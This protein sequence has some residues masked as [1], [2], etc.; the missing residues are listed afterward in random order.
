MRRAFEIEI[1]HDNPIARDH[2]V[3]GAR[4]VPG[5]TFLELVRGALR[6][7][8]ASIEIRDL[9]FHAPV[10][11]R[12]GETRRVQVVVDGARVRITSRGLAGPEDELL[13]AECIVAT[14]NGALAPD[15]TIDPG[16]LRCGAIGTADLD[17]V[18]RFAR[19]VGIEHDG[20]MRNRGHVWRG[21]DHVLLE[22][23]LSERAR[24]EANGFVLHPALL[25]GATLTVVPAVLERLG[26]ARSGHAYVPLH[27]R[28]FRCSAALGDRCL[29]LAR[30]PADPRPG[31]DVYEIDLRLFDVTGR[32][33]ATL[34][35]LSVKRVR[36]AD[37]IT[38][39]PRES[40]ARIDN[41]T[42]ALVE[43]ER[44]PLKRVR[45]LVGAL[46]GRS[47]DAL[48]PD[49]PFYD[50]GL[51]SRELVAIARGL[52]RAAG[53]PLYPT[54]LFEHDTLRRLTTHLLGETPS[55]FAETSS[56]V[57]RSPRDAEASGEPLELLL[58]TP[59]WR[60]EPIIAPAPTPTTIA[61]VDDGDPIADA[62]ASLA[63]PHL[64]VTRE[65]IG[66]CASDAAHWERFAAQFD[67]APAL[68]HVAGTPDAAMA[69]ALVLRAF[70][71]RGLRPAVL[72]VHR[73]PGPVELEAL[74]AMLACAWREQRQRGRHLTIAPDV[75]IGRAAEIVLGEIPHAD[76]APLAVRHDGARR[77]RVRRIVRLEPTAPTAGALPRREAVIVITGGAGGLARIVAQH[78]AARCSARIAL[79]GRS[80]RDA[81]VEAACAGIE[82]AGGRALYVQADV[83]DR[84]AVQDAITTVREHFGGVHGV[85]HCA[86]VLRDA[87]LRDVGTDVMQSVLAPKL[88][89]ARHLDDATRGDDLEL[90]ALFS[91]ASAWL[92]NAAQSVYAWANAS[93]DAFAHARANEVAAGRRRGRTVSIAWPL[94]AEG[95]MRTDETAIAAMRDQL[96]LAP[97]PT[98][99][100]LDALDRALASD[101]T[102][103]APLAGNAITITRA[104]LTTQP[105]DVH[106]APTVARASDARVQRA[107]VRSD[108][109]GFDEPIAIIG[110]AGRYPG[111]REPRMLHRLVAE[112]RSE[113]RLAPEGRL[114]PEA[115]SPIHGAFLDDIARFDARLF[116]ITPHEAARMAPEER[117]FLETVWE[118]LED[119]AYTR[120]ALRAQADARDGAIGVFVGTTYSNYGRF[121]HEASDR[122]RLALASLYIVPNR[123]SHWFDLDGPSLAIDT[124][125]SGSLS[126]IHLACESLRRGECSAAIAGGVS[127]LLTPWRHVGF[128]EVGML[129]SGGECRTLGDGDGLVPGEGVGAVLLK[130]LA[131]ALRDGDHVH[132]VVLGSALS[133]GG[134]T[135]S[136]TAPNPRAQARA[137]RAALARAGVTPG[138]LGWIEVAAAGLPIA[139]AIEI[140]ALGKV[141]APRE[142]P[143]AIGSLKGAI[144]HLEAASG[145]AQLTKVVFQMADAVRV[146]TP[147][148]ER[149]RTDLD[150]ERARVRPQT[151]TEPWPR[152]Q[153]EPRR[154]VVS[155]FGAGGSNAHLVIEEAPPTH[156]DMA[157]GPELV[158]LSARDEAELA[159]YA[160]RLREHLTAHPSTSL[161]RV[162]YTLQVG[163]AP[164][165]TRAAIV[166]ESLDALVAALDVLARGDTGSASGWLRGVGRAPSSLAPIYGD[167]E[168]RGMLAELVARS[169][170]SK[171]AQLWS[172]GVAF[173]WPSLRRAAGVRRLALPVRPLAGE[174][175]WI[176]TPSREVE[177]EATVDVGPPH[178]AS[179]LAAPVETGAAGGSPTAHARW[180][181]IL[182]RHASEVLSVSAAA[183][184][185]D[186]DLFDLGIDSLALMRLLAR[187]RDAHAVRVRPDEVA[188]CRT[189]ASIAERLASLASGPRTTPADVAPV[190][191]GQARPH[192]PLSLNQE[193]IWVA[194]QIAPEATA[195]HVPAAFRVRGWLEPDAL[196]RAVRALAE[197]HPAMRTQVAMIDGTPQRR[198][199]PRP[200][201]GLE[202]HE[203]PGAS[204]ET[205]EARA[206]ELVHRPFDLE[207]GPLVRVHLITGADDARVVL[208]VAHHLVCDG[209]S[210]AVLIDELTALATGA[211]LAPSP[212]TDYDEFVE[213]QRAMLGSAD[214]D[215]HRAWFRR[216]LEA[217]LEAAT[218]PYD[219][220]RGAT[221]RFAGEYHTFGL[222]GATMSALRALCR[223]RGASLYHGLLAAFEAL[224]FR[225]GTRGPIAIATGVL[226]RPEPRFEGV[227]G[228]FSNVVPLRAEVDGELAFDALLQRVRE[229]ALRAIG[230]ADMPLLEIVRDRDRELGEA[231]PLTVCFALQNWFRQYGGAVRRDA[232]AIALD[233]IFT[234]H[235]AG[236]FDLTLMIYERDDDAIA[237]LKYDPDLFDRT[238]VER[239]AGHYATLLAA[240]V[241]TPEREISALPLLSRAELALVR[242]GWASNDR[243]FPDDVSLP[244]LVERVARVRA[245]EIAVRAPDGDVR[246]AEL[247]AR[248]SRL[249]VALCE[250]GV[251][252]GE[253][254]PVLAPR[255]AGL[256]TA[257][258]GAMRAG[259]AYVPIEPRLPAARIET[260][261]ADSRAR[262][263]M[264]ARAAVPAPRALLARLGERTAIETVV[265]LDDDT[266]VEID[267]TA[268][269][270]A[271]M[272]R[273][274]FSRGAPAPR[275][276]DLTLRFAARTLDRAHLAGAARELSERLRLE[277]VHPGAPVAI[278]FSD[279]AA[280]ILARLAID[281]LGARVVSLS[282]RSSRTESHRA[283][284]ASNA[285]ALVSE[286]AHVDALDELHQRS[287][288]ALLA[289]CVDDY[290]PGALPDDKEHAIRTVFD[291]FSNVDVDELSGYGWADSYE[292]R[293]FSDAEMRE[294]V[295]NFC[296][297]LDSL[298]T[299]SSRV[300][301]IGC[302]QGLVLFE[303]APRVAEYVAT[304]LTPAIIERNLQRVARRGLSGVTLLP[305]AARE[306]DRVPGRGTYDVVIASSV[307]H[308]FPNT[309]YLEDVIDRAIDLL[310]TQGAVYIDDLLDLD[311]K[312]SV[313]EEL[314][315]F[316]A[317]HPDAAPK[318]DWD[319]DLFVG[320]AFW[321]EIARRR[322]EIVSVE[323][324][325]KLGRIPNEL[326]RFRYDV[327]LRV[328]KS[329]AGAPR[330]AGRRPIVDLALFRA[331]PLDADRESPALGDAL[332]RL[333]A[334]RSD[335]HGASAVAACDARAPKPAVGPN[336]LAYVLYTSGSTGAPKGA[337]IEHVGM[338][339]HV[340]AKVHD[341]AIGERDVIVQNASQGFDISVWQMLTA[342]CVGGR[343]LV[344]DD[345]TVLEPRAF[346]DVITSE[347]ATILEVVPS[348]LAVLLEV[349]EA[350]PQV[351]LPALR[352]LLV[353]G[354]AV[355]PS[356]VERWL[357]RFP[358]I[359][360]VNAYGPTECSD[361]V[362][363]HILRAAPE[364]ETT[365]IGVPVS[366]FRIYVVDE[367]TQ[368]VPIGVPGE[369]VVSGVGVSRGY[370]ND[371]ERTA[372]AFGI[373]PF[374]G[375]DVRLYRTG[376]L[377]RWRSDGVLEFLGRRDHQVKIRG[378]RIE[379]GEIEARLAAVEGVADAVV[380]AREDERGDKQ[381][382]GYAVPR[383][384]VMLDSDTV[385][386]QLSETLPAAMVPA[387]VV[388]LA[389]LPV[390]GNGKVDRRALPKPQLDGAA[391]N[392]ARVVEAPRGDLEQAVADAFATVLAM[393]VDHVGRD[394]DFFV[395]GGDS[396]KAIQLSTHLRARGLAVRIQDF[397]ERPRV[398][399]HASYLRRADA[400]RRE[401]V[402]GD[403][404]LSPIQRWFLATYR[405]HRD[406][407]HHRAVLRVHDVDAGALAAA[408]RATAEH[409]DLFCARLAEQSDGPAIFVPEIPSPAALEIV[410]LGDAV[411]PWQ[412][413]ESHGDAWLERFD[414]A[415]G[416]LAA[417]HL[418]RS[419]GAGDVLVITAHHI[420]V[421]ATSWRVIFEDLA[422][423][424]RDLARGDRPNLLRS[425]PFA[426]VVHAITTSA[427]GEKG[428]RDLAWFRALT[429]G[430]WARLPGRKPVA[431][432]PRG[433][434]RRVSSTVDRAR[435]AELTAGAARYCRADL[436]DVLLTVVT[437]A[438]AEWA[439]SPRVLLSMESH[440]RDLGEHVD[441]GRTVGWLASLY[442]MGVEVAADR[443]LG[444]RLKSVKE[445]LRR[446]PGGGVAYG[447]ARWIEGD[448]SLAIDPEITFDF[449]GEITAPSNAPFALDVE[450]SGLR[451]APS[452][453]QEVP[454]A[455][456]A[457][458]RDGALDIHFGFHPDELDEAALSRLLRRVD[459][460]LEELVTLLRERDHAEATPSDYGARDVE[461]D[462]L[463]EIQSALHGIEL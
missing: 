10:V 200:L 432:R 87:L 45:A 59:T 111:A 276:G 289:I 419:A 193:A 35:G 120:E 279:P 368:L 152:E 160:L 406:W 329:R 141:L 435:I 196:D 61:L 28:R 26:P 393:P 222:D 94:W 296:T 340:F 54:L 359:P 155:A 342:L 118:L 56:D 181:D 86:A 231:P 257:M 457:V 148:A 389:S 63:S 441:A 402:T 81:R 70:S 226:G 211:E 173:D 462:E 232:P 360:V 77:R 139:D 323:A 8:E 216:A 331:A 104:V 136:V 295:E 434:C 176:G 398:D 316:K 129:A 319:Q 135:P 2:R 370:L 374:R 134:R 25:D 17:R 195:Y 237:V 412:A 166:I 260:I 223:A 203:L 214:A 115:G 225:Y 162:A 202:R 235:Q 273:A 161:A 183:L 47:P 302:G 137:L 130:P 170:W 133:H 13:H 459:A 330:A 217:P 351:A 131:N 385:R 123:V 60:D 248:A 305:L 40:A 138:S 212:A 199:A 427:A 108:R 126:A 317:E 332:G 75:A 219:R 11:A 174:R 33:V 453:P 167:D 64:R 430:E 325:P 153:G 362:T 187:V 69:L 282:P 23:A 46:T 443:D 144:G 266:N 369:I 262:V 42:P 383:P 420:A 449:F 306:I 365:P 258:L 186:D 109:E 213:W 445:A 229:H 221:R 180:I 439:A 314:R 364:G 440:G 121:A 366:N 377:G 386:T 215:A 308:Y 78:F 110:I 387:H 392:E 169:R 30:M 413:I 381:L 251:E 234:I 12:E 245:A 49:Q 354:E 179:A 36:S 50:L 113:I 88:A 31:A 107:G 201:A 5:V 395:L 204:L 51:E 261:L 207:A 418:Y 349:L 177:T 416:P 208:V 382:V 218:L 388:L 456:E 415:S 27:V 3:H 357:R 197:R 293:R 52:E 275:G 450:R 447:A 230:H 233:P 425:D 236:E 390:T 93:M 149:V 18:Y 438:I 220:P 353:T 191:T 39:G 159:A 14:D 291:A 437:S 73:A 37:R 55:L 90:F 442:P 185:A 363:H 346:L 117:L 264:A 198:I 124:A 67:T 228:D 243:P 29:V 247:D 334:A 4:V 84:A 194:Q 448:V 15:P 313:E 74:H 125:C 82:A 44:D 426:D 431:A 318:L 6:G 463:T 379:L 53:Q 400:S 157:V 252:L 352:W 451:T 163:R 19:T 7:G 256:V 417:A 20:V 372:R 62:L 72:H 409:H 373:D 246:Y 91:S 22:L 58:G 239:I 297:K 254:V 277:G 265:W 454:L 361:D 48:A 210:M 127:L 320:R 336:D 95:G 280:E 321:A 145:V 98:A 324:T 367:H 171:L 284:V 396:I 350:E 156:E 281:E 267:R 43:G 178:E 337:M 338:L 309:L 283:L 89:G 343:T 79:L 103:V 38:V 298:L 255:G 300:L 259:G 250:L 99:T 433:E 269:A 140:A 85:V 403:V 421:D 57:E 310:G 422:S 21:R 154:A 294:Y 150:W 268:L 244:D 380:I 290:D 460:L 292:R 253:T 76:E 224:L 404:A 182:R 71:R 397:F 311:L 405:D 328:D 105:S 146:R 96:G 378:H 24:D 384:G 227:V 344:V 307:V 238:T 68:V 175:H 114:G 9:L 119:A 376:D 116:G 158:C 304:D 242:D 206:A 461:L 407:Y 112:G 188:D 333:A 172:A 399:A 34:D 278:L 371:P 356:L 102:V 327:L 288:G 165:D 391:S 428:R 414:L 347:G 263:L 411:D 132:G 424:L 192:A 270:G 303:I 375:T 83:A 348:Y 322:P 106:A 143:V 444:F 326:T 458:Q 286:R 16:A 41:G 315:R 274:L 80:P 101:T 272:L 100:G 341:L 287:G 394:D 335:V 312:E 32:W 97:L 271:R 429:R 241:A 205:C 301:E 436:Q 240:G 66:T 358:A 92:G 401:R 209:V 249:A 410:D 345:D 1:E 65:P 452:S 339:N 122:G 189:L 408:W 168:G 151:T 128:G 299:P 142:T 355:K 164:M 455:I 147:H 446:V 184:G 190:A 285:I 423:V